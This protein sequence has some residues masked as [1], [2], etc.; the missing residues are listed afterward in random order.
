LANNNTN[1]KFKLLS[2]F[3][4]LSYLANLLELSLA[5]KNENEVINITNNSKRD[6]AKLREEF[7]EK[8]LVNSLFLFL[9]S[10]LFNAFFHHLSSIPLICIYCFIVYCCSLLFTRFRN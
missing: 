9:F 8:D 10:S 1:T 3:A 4:N 7:E 6:L 2:S 5:S